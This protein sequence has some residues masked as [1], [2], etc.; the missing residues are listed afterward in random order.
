IDQTW[1]PANYRMYFSLPMSATVVDKR[2]YRDSGEHA[3]AKEVF[4]DDQLCSAAIGMEILFE[5]KDF[6]LV[7]FSASKAEIAVF[8]N[9]LPISTGAIRIGTW[10]LQHSLRNYIFRNHH[11]SLTDKQLEFLLF[12]LPNLGDEY[13][14]ERKAIK[15]G[16][17]REVLNPYFIIIEDQILETLERAG[18]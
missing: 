7:D 10:R 1:F 14:L 9:S 5:K 4:M 13:R 15:T 18:N 2:A 17:L 8:A 6:V 11:L 12:N 3:G 16:E